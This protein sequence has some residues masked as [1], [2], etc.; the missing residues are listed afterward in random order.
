MQATKYIQ[1]AMTL[2]VLTFTSFLSS[3]RMKQVIDMLSGLY[4]FYHYNPKAWHEL[5]A[6]TAHR[7][8]QAN[9]LRRNSLA[10]PFQQSTV[11]HSQELWAFA[12]PFGKQCGNK[13]WFS[14]DAGE[15]QTGAAGVV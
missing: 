8:L 14:R 11:H 15:G 1:I 3:D 13:I 5:K 6:I 9:Q 2:A 7:S 12:C 10:P 4:K